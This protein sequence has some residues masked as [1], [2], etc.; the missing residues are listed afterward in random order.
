MLF[1]IGDLV[2]LG[3]VLLI[4]LLFRALDRNNRSL[5]KLKRF[6]DK[7]IENLGAFIEEKTA[8]M[9]NLSEELSEGLDRGKELLNR[10]RD[11]ED[12]LSARSQSF[13][14][15]RKQIADYDRAL[16]EL[17]GLS[18]RVDHDVK[19]IREEAGFVD[20]VEKRLKEA[21]LEIARLENEL[22]SVRGAIAEAGRQGREAVA[23][24]IARL[25]KDIPAWEEKLTAASR[26]R[27]DAVSAQI[28]RLEKEIP[29]QQEKLS[30]TG[31]QGVESVMAEIA[32]IKKEM[33][34]LKDAIAATGQQGREA[35]LSEIA[36]MKRECA[37]V[38]DE[39]DAACR[40]GKETVAA[41]VSR[42][43]KEIPALEEK[44]AE[45]G[46]RG[47]ESVSGEIV[48]VSG[49]IPALKEAIATAARQGREEVSAEFA[50]MQA[51]IPLLEEKLTAE[52]RQRLEAFAVEIIRLEKQIPALDEK[53][54]NAGRQ[55]LESV[56]GEVVRIQ[57]EIPFLQEKFAAANRK[58]IEEAAAHVLSSVEEITRGMREDVDRS[59][60]KIKD[61]AAYIARLDASVESVEKERI[62]SLAK[63]LDSF[64]VDLRG[65]RS[66]LFEEVSVQIGSLVAEAE[67]QLARQRHLLEEGAKRGETLE[68]EVFARLRETIQNDEVALGKAIEKIEL[69]LQDY[70]GEVDYRFKK[71]EEVGSDVAAL[72]RSLRDS[73]ENTAAGAREEMKKLSGELVVEWNSQIA[74]VQSEKAR[75][76]AGMSELAEG[77]SNLKSSAYQDV[78]EKLQVFED[79]FFADLR[80]RSSSMQEKIQGWQGE[81]EKRLSD[82]ALKYALEREKLEKT[83]QE[84]LRVSFENLK[85]NSSEELARIELNVTGLETS[86]RERISGSEESLAELRES[87]RSEMEKTRKDSSALFER[88]LAAARDEADVATKKMQ[89]DLE[90]R[91]KGLSGELEAGKKELAEMMGAARAELVVWQG[92]VRQQMTETEADLTEN[93]S[94]ASA[95][96]QSAIGNIRD[97][98]AA[99]KEQLIVSTNGERMELQNELDLLGERLAGF[100]TELSRTTETAVESLRKELEA[101]QLESQ[102]RMRD[103]QTDVEARIKEFKILLGENREK[104]EAQQEK[105]FG[106]IEE[107]YRLLTVDLGEIDKRVKGFV[108]QTKVFE[109]ADA[110]KISLEGSI[111]E[112][113][114]ELTKM[115]AERA[116]LTE[117]EVQLSKTKRLAEEVSAK[118]SRFLAEKRR[119]EDMDGEFKK[120]LTMSREVD[121]KLDTLTSSNDALQ[122]IQAK[123]RQFEEMGREVENGFERLE[124]KQEIITVTSEGVE[125]NFQR[126]EGIEKLLSSAGREAENLSLKVQS[127]RAD[128]EAMAVSKKDA[129]SVMRIAGELDGTMNELESRLEKAQG[130]REW[131]AR[132][133][134]RF[135]E[136]GKQAQEQVRLLESI[137]KAE[138]KTGKGDRGAPPLDKRETVIK[139]S[140]QGWSVQEI[141]RVTQLSRGEVELILEL[142]PKV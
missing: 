136:I 112:M 130:A 119:I 123:I 122:Q 78:S 75:L 84:E 57:E 40:L 9:K 66:A 113:K 12:A 21:S 110:L 82:I 36:R 61:F 53:L 132:T 35:I 2:T 81:V 27:L 142:A 120:I 134:T 87:V 60:A 4:L 133:E 15:V 14:S 95:D 65:R 25:E 38:K 126:L 6:S 56:N 17:V 69:R 111:E 8:R 67:S 5:E 127:L 54:A 48:R 73:M 109:R 33:P 76:A 131:L 16:G 102:K 3:I 64:E 42:I 74:S 96:A 92:R 45:A 128:L 97:E 26:Q 121:L 89:R 28:T 106:K 101:F 107:S 115:N 1:S 108:G 34:V 51:E 32:R 125:K 44:L 83:Y 98:F 94:T 116:D 41:E 20:G 62:S 79:E 77:L 71:L 7:I 23:A 70:E 118:L 29:A 47:L 30:S 58:S 91:L 138:A 18:G 24:Q 140:H 88:E 105:L 85:K 31:R 22:P 43:E 72:D 37:A 55:G 11:A 10:V 86:V 13:D 90:L 19:R 80:G 52:S 124:K 104:A 141:S 49:E 129:D 139:L 114:K 93:I 63:T 68:G 100:Q 117:I 99:Q 103:T 137:L 135:E 59:E 39:I 46:R 50:R